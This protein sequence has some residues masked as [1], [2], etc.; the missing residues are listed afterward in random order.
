MF[1]DSFNLWMGDGLGSEGSGADLLLPVVEDLW[2][3]DDSKN[4]IGDFGASKSNLWLSLNG[5]LLL[6]GDVVSDGD[7]ENVLLTILV[8]DGVHVHGL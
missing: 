1:V 6:S 4:I 2:V 8:G 7:G 5:S 3:L